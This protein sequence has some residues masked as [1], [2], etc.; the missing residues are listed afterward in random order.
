MRVKDIY[1]LTVLTVALIVAVALITTHKTAPFD[2]KNR[3]VEIVGYD[4]LT[5]NI[6]DTGT[7]IGYTVDNQDRRINLNSGPLGMC[8]IYLEKK[9]AKEINIG[10]K[11]VYD[12]VARQ[13]TK[14]YKNYYRVP[15]NLRGDCPPEPLPPSTV[16]GIPNGGR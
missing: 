8:Y 12:I 15:C 14:I 9:P 7:F 13:I 16:A 2:E 1:L 5:N 10:D 3:S 6:N 4:R 11:V